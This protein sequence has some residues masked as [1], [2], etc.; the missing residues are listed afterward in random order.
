MKNGRLYLLLILFSVAVLY[1]YFQFAG[2]DPE[3]YNWNRTF[4][5]GTHEPYDFG[6][7]RDLL[8]HSTRGKFIELNSFEKQL[9]PSD[10]SE[11]NTYLFAGQYCFL[12]RK[13]IDSLL[14]FAS[15]G[16]RVFIISEG[17]P[18]T[19]L[20]VLGTRD[21]Q[22]LFRKMDMSEVSIGLSG[23]GFAQE[24]KF[25]F[26]SF[27][28]RT[29]ECPWFYLEMEKRDIHTYRVDK[30]DSITALGTVNDQLNFAGF[31]YG[32][33][34]FYL[35][36]SPVLFT[37]YALRTEIG[38]RYAD[39]VMDNLTSGDVYYDAEARIPYPDAEPVARHS[40]APLSFI[41]SQPALKTAWYIFLA[42]CVIFVV[43]KSRRMQRIVPVIS[44]KRNTSLAFIDSLSGMYETKA[45]H[46]ATAEIIMQQLQIFI[47]MEFGL[48]ISPDNKN[49]IALLAKRSGVAE[50]NIEN[51]YNYYEQVF[52]N[53]TVRR[54]HEALMELHAR[55]QN[56]Y[57][58]FEQNKQ[59]IWKNKKN[60]KTAM[61]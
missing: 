21:R 37:N 15:Y 17:L 1:L 16:N 30:P 26:R 29:A 23:Q 61:H 25:A 34:T 49:S 9:T 8:R 20:E 53:S 7:F 44:E 28:R 41:L 32:A 59:S 31:E 48:Q 38:F 47:R 2:K 27:E 33:G 54:G 11:G 39:R 4:N 18:D 43:Y 45:D 60:G 52:K 12:S 42:T 24:Y 14:T 35:L 56:F 19:L 10:G 3:R 36:S 13:K 22:P 5:D 51:I 6:A 40:E 46:A 50:S 57:Q 55:V 58:L